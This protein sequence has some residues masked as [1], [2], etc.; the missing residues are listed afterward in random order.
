MDK[1]RIGHMT[2]GD[3]TV[4]TIYEIPASQEM[5]DKYHLNCDMFH[6]PVWQVRSTEDV[7]E[8]WY[9]ANASYFKYPV[10]HK[11]EGDTYDE[12]L[13]DIKKTLKNTGKKAA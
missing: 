2:Q 3:T 13:A 8:I 9:E 4:S 5:A 10:Y 7:M 11:A 6:P 12:A 1:Y